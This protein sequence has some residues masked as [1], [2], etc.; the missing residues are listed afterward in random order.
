[1][2]AEAAYRFAREDEA[3]GDSPLLRRLL[4]RPSDRLRPRSAEA[5]P[6]LPAGP[7]PLLARLSAENRVI[8]AALRSERAV[9]AELRA[10]LAALGR[11]EGGD[12]RSHTVL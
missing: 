3:I 10:S 9:A 2:M 11:P 7:D 8:K 4:V 12:A 5:P 6:A 1:M